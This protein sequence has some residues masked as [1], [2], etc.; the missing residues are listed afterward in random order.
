MLAGKERLV[1]SGGNVVLENMEDQLIDDPELD[2]VTTY[3]PNVVRGRAVKPNDSS[4]NGP[5]KRS[6]KRHVVSSIEP[7]GVT[8]AVVSG[9]LRPMHEQ[10]DATRHVDFHDGF[11]T[12]ERGGRLVKEA[13]TVDVDQHERAPAI[14][15]ALVL[16]KLQKRRG[17]SH[18]DIKANMVA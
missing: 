8:L 11:A 6:I 7:L 14:V 13:I 10:I 12:R 3:E 9:D 1:R 5:A 16:E 17:H 18:Q 2:F 4:I 15:L